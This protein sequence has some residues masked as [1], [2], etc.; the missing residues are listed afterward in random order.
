VAPQHH[1]D[2]STRLPPENSAWPAIGLEPQIW[3]PRLPMWGVQS[4]RD[5][6]AIGATYQSAVP[7]AIAELEFAPRRAV[8]AAAEDASTAIVRFDAELGGEIA[9]FSSVLLRTESVASSQIENLSASARSIAMAELGDCSKDNASLIA[10]NTRAMRAAVDLADNLDVDAVLKMHEALLRDHDPDIA[11]KFRTEAV[12]IGRRGASPIGADY[13]APDHRR[14]QDAMDD[15][16]AYINRTDIPVL[17]RVAIAHAQFETLHPFPDG[18]GRTG[19]A[20]MHSMLRAKG[21]TRNVTVPV[22]S[23]LLAEV[24]SYYQSLTDYRAGNPEPIITVTADAAFRAINNAQQL[25][26]DLLDLRANWKAAVKARSDS[27]VWRVMDLLLRQPI[28]NTKVL[29][30]ELGIASKHADRHMTVLKDAGIVSSFTA[31]QRGIHWKADD[32]LGSLDDFARRSGRRANPT[33]L[34]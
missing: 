29:Q 13:V 14:L 19:R 34:S 4:R 2:A 8:S 27:A 7:A 9:P 21:L 30:Y 5:Q 20:L 17:E 18:N 33:R 3:E 24:D 12:W 22:S 26:H 16:M 10:T 15:L 1:R 6:A 28:I 23:G 31:Y 11:G 25:V 32:V